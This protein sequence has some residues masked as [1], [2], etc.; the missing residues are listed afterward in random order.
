VL[1]PLRDLAPPVRPTPPVRPNAAH[2]VRSEPALVALPGP[3]VGRP[4][5]HR[6]RGTGAHGG[7]GRSRTS[8]SRDDSWTATPG[9]TPGRWTGPTP[10]WPA[11]C[12]RS[13]AGPSSGTAGPDPRSTIHEDEYPYI[14]QTIVAA[15]PA[16]GA[17]RRRFGAY[18]TGSMRHPASGLRRMSLPRT[19]MNKT[20]PSRA[21]EPTRS[22]GECPWRGTSQGGGRNPARVTVAS[23]WTAASDGM[24]P[25]AAR[26][27]RQ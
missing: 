18:R 25:A 22:P 17:R 9:A 14:A 19:R 15:D 2:G 11:R 12:S 27:W 4:R 21:R 20:A 10:R 8:R 5:G 13:C 7:F 6:V 1:L 26:A 24:L 23:R 16:E 3:E